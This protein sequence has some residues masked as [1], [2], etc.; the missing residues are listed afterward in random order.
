MSKG[1]ENEVSMVKGRPGLRAADIVDA[2]LCVVKKYMSV[3]MGPKNRE[4]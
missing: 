3:M 4:R 2:R 1:D